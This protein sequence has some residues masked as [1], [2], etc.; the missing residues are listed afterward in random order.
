MPKKVANYLVI[1][2]LNGKSSLKFAFRFTLEK[3]LKKNKV[4]V[5]FIYDLIL[6]M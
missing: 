3:K 6:F 5:I 1:K 4:P 2:L